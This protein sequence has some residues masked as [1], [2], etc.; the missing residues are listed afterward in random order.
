MS[1]ELKTLSTR[2]DGCFSVLLFNT[3]PCLVTCERTFMGPDGIEAPV[4]QGGSHACRRSY[5]N[6]GNY[7][8]FEILVPGHD[9]VKFHK[10]SVEQDSQACV[11]VG[12]RF[13][14]LNGQTSIHDCQDAMNELM[15]LTAGLD[16]FE[17]VVTGR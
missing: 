5:F 6:R 9:F 12:K 11:L 1:F 17:L 8:T 2:P 13:G 14:F 7:P 4:M 3:R 15:A 16:E 10:G